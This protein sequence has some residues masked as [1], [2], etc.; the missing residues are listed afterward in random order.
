VPN[1]LWRDL[2]PVEW[3]LIKLGEN[4]HMQNATWLVSREIAEA[5]GPWDESLH[6]DQD[7]EYFARVLLA[8]TGVRFVPEGRV[9]Y[10]SS[11]ANRV[12]FI[13]SSRKKKDSLLRSMKLHVQ[14]ARSLEDSERVHQA[15]LKYLQTWYGNFSPDYAQGMD[16]LQALATELSGQLEA[17]NLSRKYAWM[18]P[19]FGREAAHWSQRVLPEV[20]S[21]LHRQWD[22][23][24]FEWE[25]HKFAS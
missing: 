21:R 3:L 19:P 25:Q 2:T 14:Y 22:K 16:E 17:P 4:L 20:K 18:V 1:S 11:G 5:A 6:Y 8:S 24:M 15:C 12:S 10:R 7:G 13:G 9:Y 23:L